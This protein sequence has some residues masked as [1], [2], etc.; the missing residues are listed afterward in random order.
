MPENYPT[1][2]LF[3]DKDFEMLDQFLTLVIEAKKAGVSVKE[4]TSHLLLQG[5]D[6]EE[7]SLILDI[8]ALEAK[9]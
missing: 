8:I 2:N 1:S 6:E 5:M 3:Y 4:I 9:K 7:V